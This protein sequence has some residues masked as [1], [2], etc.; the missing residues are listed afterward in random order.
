MGQL[1]AQQGEHARAVRWQRRAAGQY[2]ALGDGVGEGMALVA[3]GL[4]LFA[5]QHYRGV[6]RV[7]RRAAVA[8]DQPNGLDHLAM[9]YLGQGAAYDRLGQPDRALA[10][11]RLAAQ[12]LERQAAGWWLPELELSL[13]GQ[14][15]NLYDRI[16]ALSVQLGKTEVALETVETQ[17]SR[18]FL[19]QL[20]LSAPLAPRGASPNQIE[21]EQHSLAR[22]RVLLAQQPSAARTA[23]EWQELNRIW[24]D[25]ESIWRDLDPEYASLRQG[26]PL[27]VEEIRRLL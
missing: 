11:Y 4:S 25:L 19:S 24:A 15:E 8:A 10:H 22:L 12:V 2:R 27:S 21:R 20:G 6:V 17:R 5:L 3:L 23:Q 1:A 13:F 9:A 26:K 7:L 16:V 18:A 14:R